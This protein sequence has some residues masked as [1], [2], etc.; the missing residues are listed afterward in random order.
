MLISLLQTAISFGALDRIPFH[1]VL[2]GVGFL[3]VELIQCWLVLAD[4]GE[5]ED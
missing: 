1:F 3:S 4:T 5:G 2:S